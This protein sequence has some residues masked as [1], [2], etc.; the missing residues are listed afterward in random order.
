MQITRTEKEFVNTFIF[1]R[2]FYF[3]ILKYLGECNDL[4]AQSDTS[5]LADVFENFRIMYLEIY[6]INLPRFF[7]TPGL[8]WKDQSKIRFFF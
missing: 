6:E 2:L 8:A 5:L 3:I 1:K 7:M 4:R